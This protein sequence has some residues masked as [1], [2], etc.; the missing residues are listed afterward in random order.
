MSSGGRTAPALEAA[1]KA[2]RDAG[3]HM[4]ADRLAAILAGFMKSK[5][6]SAHDLEQTKTSMDE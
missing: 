2:A 6:K 3:L 5:D 1:I 4:I